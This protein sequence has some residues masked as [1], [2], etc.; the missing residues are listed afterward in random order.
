M[1]LIKNKNQGKKDGNLTK[2]SELVELIDDFHKQYQALYTLYDNLKGEVKEKVQDLE[3][4]DSS[5]STSSSDSESY[6]SVDEAS[7]RSSPRH[8]HIQRVRDDLKNKLETPS[9][10]LIDM[11]NKLNVISE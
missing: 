1:K 9:L 5:S 10:E 6:H 2:D 8:A 11:R 7:A 4:K 3:N